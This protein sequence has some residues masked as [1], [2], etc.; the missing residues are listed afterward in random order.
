MLDVNVNFHALALHSFMYFTFSY[1]VFTSQ[2][3]KIIVIF[4]N[5]E[6]RNVTINSVNGKI[7]A[8]K[9]QETI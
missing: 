4:P 7:G 3:E 6:Q 5:C 2:I 8:S 1:Q 9:I